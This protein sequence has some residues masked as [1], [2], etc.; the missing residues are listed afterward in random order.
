VILVSG[1]HAE[2]FKDGAPA[3]KALIRPVRYRRLKEVAHVPLALFLLGGAGSGAAP[4]GS[5]GLA[6]RVEK[7]RRGLGASFEGAQLHRQE[8]ILDICLAYLREAPLPETARGVFL[9]R[10]APLVQANLKDAAALQLERLHGAVGRWR[11]ALGPQAWASVRVVV[12]GS[13]MAREGELTWQYFARL[14]GEG[15]E[16]ERMELR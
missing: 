11:G 3:G 9:A 13:H 16:G 10:V 4:G 2:L 1:D 15:G 14:L 5:E 6:A 7:A 12:C 8:A